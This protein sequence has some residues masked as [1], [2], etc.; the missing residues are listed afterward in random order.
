GVLMSTT[1]PT[2]TRPRTSLADT[3]RRDLYLMR[4]GWAMEDYPSKPGKQIRKD[5]RRDLKV[6][7][8]EV[9]TQQA[10]ADLGHPRVLAE[11]YKQELGRRL[12]SYTT[13][14]VAAG[15]VVGM[16]VYLSLAFALGVHSTLE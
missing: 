11:R 2:A 5:L 1:T 4:F 8:A 15:L 13:G 9:G 12:P 16:L 3:L 7:E 6:A 10:L 14:A